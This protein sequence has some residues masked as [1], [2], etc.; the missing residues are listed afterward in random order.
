MYR[1][2][3]VWCKA[4]GVGQALHS[5]FWWGDRHDE[6]ELLWYLGIDQV[7]RIRSEASPDQRSLDKPSLEAPKGAAEGGLL[8]QGLI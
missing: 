8:S 1:L 7:Q 4:L 2:Q 5:F 6:V 3:S